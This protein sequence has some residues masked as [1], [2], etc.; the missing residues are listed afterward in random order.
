MPQSIG[1]DLRP[2]QPAIEARIARGLLRHIRQ[3]RLVAEA[4]STQDAAKELA[5]QQPGLLVIADRQTNGRGRLGRRW[6]TGRGLGVSAT[7]VVRA[8]QEVRQRMALLLGLAACTT[9]E[10]ALGAR[11]LDSGSVDPFAL[12][13]VDES[14]AVGEAAGTPSASNTPRVGLRWPNDV[15]E[16][17]EGRPARKLAGVLVEAE[18]DLVFA[19]IGVNVDQHADDWGDELRE[20]AASLRQLGG[21]WPRSRVAVALAMAVDA[22]LDRGAESV[23]EA[24]SRRNVLVGRRCVFLH[25]RERYVGRVRAIDPLSRVELEVDGGEVVRLPAETTSLIEIE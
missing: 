19:G 10:A 1:N 8:S 23:V 6:E 21:V 5:D 25:D 3:V 11:T 20:R 2:A 22:W 7:F 24:W 18:W 9:V 4:G 17:V 16:V 15:V 12:K 14:A 13:L